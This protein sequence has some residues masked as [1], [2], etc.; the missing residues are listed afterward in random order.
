MQQ[1]N[2]R[3]QMMS[4]VDDDELNVHKAP[5]RARWRVSL[6]M[7]KK[8]IYEMFLMQKDQVGGQVWTQRKLL[9][10]TLFLKTEHKSKCKR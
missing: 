6:I 8:D 4:H 2:A 9:K 1:R 5:S 10:E 7:K 3:V